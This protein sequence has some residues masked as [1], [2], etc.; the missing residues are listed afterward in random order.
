M[1]VIELIIV[2]VISNWFN[3]QTLRNKYF[4]LLKSQD[5]SVNILNLRKT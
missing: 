1:T 5:K 2:L 3:I 4:I